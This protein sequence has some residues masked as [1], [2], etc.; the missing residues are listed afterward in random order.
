MINQI[1]EEIKAINHSISYCRGQLR[2]ER[3]PQ[4]RSKIKKYMD[5][6]ENELTAR[7]EKVE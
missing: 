4:I 7:L 1:E 2:D 6:L 3:D 5:E